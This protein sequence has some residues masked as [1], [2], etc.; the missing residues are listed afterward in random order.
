[1]GPP[2]LTGGE[3][4]FDGEWNASLVASMGPPELTGGEVAVAVA[5]PAV[6]VELQWGRRN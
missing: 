2:E 3:V 4:V 6:A 5:A 1:M